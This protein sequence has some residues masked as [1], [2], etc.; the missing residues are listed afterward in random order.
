LSRFVPRDARI[1]SN[2]LG[3]PPIDAGRGITAGT[4]VVSSKRPPRGPRAAVEKE[5][6]ALSGAAT[7]AGEPD[8]KHP[9]SAS[10]GHGPRRSWVEGKP[11]ASR[12]RSASAGRNDPAF[13]RMGGKTEV[14]P[15]PSSGLPETGPEEVSARSTPEFGAG[16]GGLVPRVD[17]VLGQVPGSRFGEVDLMIRASGRLVTTRDA[18]RPRTALDP[19]PFHRRARSKARLGDIDTKN[20]P[21]RTRSRGINCL[22]LS[23]L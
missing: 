2:L 21:R 9:I 8:G 6:G 4:G 13:M 20:L 3:V 19:R 18:P 7:S 16:G 1:G 15:E 5:G 17:L 22:R 14:G 10:P 11:R 12:T 23:R